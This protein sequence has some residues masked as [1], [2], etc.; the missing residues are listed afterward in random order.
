MLNAFDP[1]MPAVEIG[2]RDD[3]F[4]VYQQAGGYYLVRLSDWAVAEVATP[5]S[6]L[7]KEEVINWANPQFYWPDLT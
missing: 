1:T 6:W 3:G 4:A 5:P 7:S 2:L